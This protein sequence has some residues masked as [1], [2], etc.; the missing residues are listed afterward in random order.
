MLVFQSGDGRHHRGRSQDR[1]A[2]AAGKSVLPQHRRDAGRP[3][4]L[5][6]PVG[7]TLV[8]EMEDRRDRLVVIVTGY[9]GPMQSFLQSNPGLPSRF[10]RTIRF[11]SYSADELVQEY[12][13]PPWGTEVQKWLRSDRNCAGRCTLRLFNRLSGRGNFSGATTKLRPLR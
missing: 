9:D 11:G 3:P 7:D 1:R 13:V 5:A 2:P 8:K 12:L 6:H 4:G 10:A